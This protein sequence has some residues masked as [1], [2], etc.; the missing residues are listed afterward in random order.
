MLKRQYLIKRNVKEKNITA[1]DQ[2]SVFAIFSVQ[3]EHFVIFF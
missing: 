3:C 1:N 2:V